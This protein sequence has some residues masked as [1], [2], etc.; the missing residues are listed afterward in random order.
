MRENKNKITRLKHS[1][2]D[3]DLNARHVISQYFPGVLMSISSDTGC[4]SNESHGYCSWTN[5]F[6][7]FS[8]HHSHPQPSL[9]TPE[10]PSCSCLCASECK[11]ACVSDKRPL[12]ALPRCPRWNLS[13]TNSQHKVQL[14]PEPLH[15]VHPAINWVWI[16]IRS[17]CRHFRR[18]IICGV[19]IVYYY[20]IWLFPLLP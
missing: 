1:W 18:W 14:C 10:G 20:P 4:T 6:S 17:W 5:T 2:F 16:L 3:D 7:F 8:Q 12:A 15:S 13:N 11:W 9:H 19:V